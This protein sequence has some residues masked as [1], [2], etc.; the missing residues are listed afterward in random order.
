MLVSTVG[1]CLNLILVIQVTQL[2]NAES[3]SIHS[4]RHS[5]G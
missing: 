3:I 2:K 5:L 4:T 1:I